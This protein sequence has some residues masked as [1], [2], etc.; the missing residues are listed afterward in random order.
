VSKPPRKIIASPKTPID[1]LLD[2]GSLSARLKMY[3]TACDAI[4]RALNLKPSILRGSVQ[5]GLCVFSEGRAGASSKLS[6]P[7]CRA[8]P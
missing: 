7:F 5:L 4:F 6:W 3:D 2:L 8:R 1:T